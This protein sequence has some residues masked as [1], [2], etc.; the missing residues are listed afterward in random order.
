MCCPS[1]QVDAILLINDKS[2]SHARHNHVE[3]DIYKQLSKVF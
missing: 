3:A 2:I 1:R